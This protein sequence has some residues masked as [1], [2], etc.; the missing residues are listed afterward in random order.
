MPFILSALET[1]AEALEDTRAYLAVC[2]A[3]IPLIVMYNTVSSFFRGMGNTRAP[4]IFIAI[5]GLLNIFLDFLLIGHYHMGAAGAAWGTLSSEGLSVLLALFFLRVKFAPSTWP[6]KTSGRERNGS[7][8]S[9]VSAFPF[10]A[11]TASSRSPSSSSPPLPT[12]AAWKQPL[13]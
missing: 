2:F 1:P 7:A 6:W 11:R 3:G 8:R 4:M 10:P 9:W 13:P 5:S 12:A